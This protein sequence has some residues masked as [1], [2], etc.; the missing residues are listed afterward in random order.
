MLDLTTHRQSKAEE[1]ANSI[2]HG[3]A[4]LAS[5][6]AV[7]V[8]IIFSVRQG[9]TLG[10]VGACVF[11]GA[12]ILLYLTSSI[13]HALPR[14]RVKRAFRLL[15]HTAIF[16]MIAGTYT[17]FALGV[18][19]GPWGWSIL[20]A[21]WTLAIAG[22]ILDANKWFGY[23]KLGTLVYLGMGWISLIAIKPLL[24]MVPV[25]GLFWLLGGGLFYTV[26]VLFFT[27][28][29]VRFSHFIWHLFVIGGT[30]CHFFAVL[31]YAG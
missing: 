9:N 19:K 8:L 21:I 4:F 13:Y 23:P 10:M 28:E 29:R 24:T 5:V 6:V 11:G 12:T 18:L 30:V 15:D 2:S 31:W 20:T 25:P 22:I 3:A 16:L 26:G 7:P 14:N 17:P 27:A 1:I